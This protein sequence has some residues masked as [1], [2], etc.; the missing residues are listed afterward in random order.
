[1]TCWPGHIEPKK[2]AVWFAWLGTAG[3][4]NVRT[5]SHTQSRQLQRPAWPTHPTEPARAKLASHAPPVDAVN[6]EFERYENR[7][8]ELGIA[9]LD[10]RGRDC[11]TRHRVRGRTGALRP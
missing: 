5:G 7:V 11:Y 2:S 3:S 9:A 6:R 8:A 4:G 1:M 10:S